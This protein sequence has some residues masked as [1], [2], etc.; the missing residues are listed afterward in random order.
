M[1]SILTKL[2]LS[3]VVCS[4]LWK[5]FGKSFKSFLAVGECNLK[6]EYINLFCSFDVYVATFLFYARSF[7]QF[8]IDLSIVNILSSNIF[9]FFIG[10]L[11]KT[12]VIFM[13]SFSIFCLNSFTF[14]SNYT[15]FELN[16]IICDWLNL[17]RLNIYLYKRIVFSSS[18][19]SSFISS[20]NCCLDN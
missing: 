13:L 11:I 4:T 19:S 9:Y 15:S 20:K 8:S 7:S 2:K 3:L 12:S 10:F 16:S 14:Y 17:L 18:Y 1:L 5:R 6:R